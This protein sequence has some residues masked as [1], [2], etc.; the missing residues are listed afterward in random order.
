MKDDADL[1]AIGIEGGDVI[2]QRFVVSAM[3]LVF[4]AVAQEVL[5]ELADHVFRKGD[6][7]EG[8]E[9]LIHDIGIPGDFLLVACFELGDVQAPEQVLDLTIREL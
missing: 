5:M 9:H 2:G 4:G 1:L 7:P 8:I 3:A 6:L